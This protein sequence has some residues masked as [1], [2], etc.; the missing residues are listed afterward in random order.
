MTP[1]K[2]SELKRKRIIDAA[3]KIFAE[4]G[5]NKGTISSIAKEADVGKGTIYE[6]FKSKDEIFEEMLDD[7]FQNMLLNWK[8]LND[9]KM[10]AIKKLEKIFD[11]T[12]E[13]LSS[14]DNQNFHQL[15][16]IIE[17]MLYAI[18]KDL[19]KS[20]QINLG[21]ILRKLYKIIDPIIEDGIKEGVLRDIDKEY[22]T[23]ILFSS[24]D[25][26]SLHYYLQRDYVDMGKLKK[27]SME[28]FFNGILENKN[29]PKKSKETGFW[30]VGSLPKKYKK[31][32]K[33]EEI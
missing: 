17:I 25:G 30:G 15:I 10:P 29:Q 19:Q 3:M 12:F 22:F 13:Y 16:I 7:Y 14:I 33:L 9:I 2:K 26:I 28:M 27:Y 20:T 21:K 4:K 6:Y 23:L 31:K 1:L 24:L 32:L 5:I 18:R 11:Y 8:K